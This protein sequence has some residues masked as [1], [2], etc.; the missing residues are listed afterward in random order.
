MSITQT[1]DRVERLAAL[2][3]AAGVDVMLVTDLINLRYITGF[4]GTNGAALVGPSTR[5]FATDFRYTELAAEQVDPAF[6]RH[7]VP[8]AVLSAIPQLLPE[9]ELRLGFEASQMPFSIYTSFLDLLPDRVALVPVDGLVERMRAVKE[10]REIERMRAA[11]ALADAALEQLL[12]GGLAG[13]TERDVALELE[14]TMRKLGAEQ[15]SFE[16]I[17]A[18]G[19]QGALPHSAPRDVE[20]GAGELVVIDWGARLDGYCSDC[21]RTIATGETGGLAREVYALVLD[22][23]LT[24][25]RATRAGAGKREVDGAA[26]SVIEAAGY[27]ERFGHGL[28]HGVGLAI[29]EH[30]RLTRTAEGELE[31]G[32]AVTI[33][34]GIY[35]PGQFGVR[36]EDLVVVTDDGCEILTSLSKEL[37]VVE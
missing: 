18:A 3:P 14:I 36:I 25:L 9:G 35:L 12:A 7:E 27:G 5:V 26:R 32:N 22:A 23:Q 37:T 15:V 17:V 34:P 20:I 24:G 1:S 19:P 2:L 16:P 11:A 6:D 21:T 30:P 33:E 10:P 8:R 4:V 28:G 29:H 13:R 31:A